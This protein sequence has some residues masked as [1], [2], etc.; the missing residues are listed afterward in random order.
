MSNERYTTITGEVIEYPP[1][2]AETTAFLSRAITAANDPTVSEAQ[3]VEL[4]Y[5]LDNPILDQ[6]IFP[7]RGAVTAAVFADPVYRVLTDLIAQKQVLEGRLD[8]AKSTA[9]R[10]MTV[11][12]AAERIGITPDAVR[13]AIKAGRLSAVKRGQ[14][15]WIDPRDADNY[16]T[17][18]LPRGRAKAK[19]AADDGSAPADEEKAPDGD[20]GAS[21][22]SP[23]LRVRCGS[24]PGRSLRI[25]TALSVRTKTVGR[26][27][28]VEVPTFERALVATSSTKT[29]HLFVLEPADEEGRIEW[30]PFFVEGRFRIVEED[31]DARRA[32]E[33]FRA[34]EP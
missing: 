4:I 33:R 27:V 10:T 11:L 13:K 6:S 21:A 31:T 25:K 3:L 8:V 26:V 12:E 34:F 23:A 17:H 30:G 28:D 16:R 5:G 29:Q 20:V 32:G 7:G 2:S 19:K 18:V 9:G 24:T 22:G 1:Q 14:A 15:H